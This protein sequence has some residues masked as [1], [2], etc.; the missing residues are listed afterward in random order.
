VELEGSA[1]G[2]AQF[3][4]TCDIAQDI[5]KLEQDPLTRWTC[6]MVKGAVDLK[7]VWASLLCNVVVVNTNRNS[8]ATEVLVIKT[9]NLAP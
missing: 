9:V 8:A 5:H 2:E 7:T 6:S 4:D 3:R 1:G